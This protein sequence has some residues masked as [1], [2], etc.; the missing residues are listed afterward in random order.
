[1]QYNHLKTVKN[2]AKGKRVSR[3]HIYKLIKGRQINVVVIDGVRFTDVTAHGKIH[4]N[5]L[6]TI[7]NYAKQNRVTPQFIYKLIK[8]GK[9]GVVI[10]DGIR[11]IDLSKHLKYYKRKKGQKL[12]IIKD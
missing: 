7:K 1:M 2:Y 9:M 4:Y 8:E 10:I 12:Y 6:R 3:Q 5:H 11:F